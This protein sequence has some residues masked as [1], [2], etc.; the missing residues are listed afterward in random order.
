M[1]LSAAL[2]AIAFSLALSVRGE[3]ERASTSVDSLRSYY[4][5]R[6]AVE[7]AALELLW[8]IG[9]P[10][11]PI[12]PNSIEVQYHFESGDAR[13]EFIPET[14]KMDLNTASPEALD[15]LLL[16][17][18]VDP[19]RA[20]EIATAIADWRAGSPDNGPFDAYY[21]SQKPPF[22][23]PHFPFQETEELL[24]VKGVTPEIYYGGFSV[25]GSDSLSGQHVLQRQPGLVDCVTV[26][27]SGGL[28]DVNT[29]SPAVL[30]ALGIPAPV[31]GMILQQRRTAPF[32]QQL[33]NNFIGSTGIAGAPLRVGG[34]AIVTIRAT[35][36]LRLPDGRLSDLRR[37]L[38]A[39][40]KYLN[41]KEGAGFHILRWYD[42]AWSN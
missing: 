2:A 19:A 1:W 9:N 3:T 11:P 27:G 10:T 12:P 34:I 36:R 41:P 28:V 35:G 7:R 39:Q 6:G 17:L 30:A 25:S 31:V 26:Y 14:A 32:T 24:Q 4:L 42:T 18:N 38:A 13:V 8:S 40:V 5:A 21:L 37:T 16:S 23:S 22:V 33:L 20:F 29:A 15:R